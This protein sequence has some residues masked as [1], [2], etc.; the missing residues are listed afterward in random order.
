MVSSEKAR[1]INIIGEYREKL[2]GGGII[3]LVS[4]S[5]VSRVDGGEDQIRWNSINKSLEA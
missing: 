2:L 3:Q 4:Y 1:Y 5:A